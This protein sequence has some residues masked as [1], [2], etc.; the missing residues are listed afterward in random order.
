MEQL[1][2]SEDKF[3]KAFQSSPLRVSIS[4]LEEGRFVEVNETFLRDHGF[5]R[6]QV[7]G[8][9][10]PELGLWAD[11]DQRRRLVDTIRRNGMV[12][13]YEY[14]GQLRDGRIQTT[15]ISAEV[16][17]VGGEACLLSVATDVT[18]RKEA[19]EKARRCRARSCVPWPRDS[20][21][22]AR[23][24]GRES[25]GRSTTSWARR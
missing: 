2:F 14:A 15:S 10:S 3:A 7:I 13:D 22:C 19:E 17:Q 18:E 24:S 5:T 12:R 16:I 9:T 6:E 4:T 11:P 20:C 25:H 21:W 8:R 23:R 1:R